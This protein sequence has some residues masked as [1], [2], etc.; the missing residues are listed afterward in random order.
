MEG[1]IQTLYSCNLQQKDEVANLVG[2]GSMQMMVRVQGQLEHAAVGE[3]PVCVPAVLYLHSFIPAPQAAL[4][5]T[6]IPTC[7][8]ICMS[9]LSPCKFML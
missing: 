4:G 3:E 1:Q 8:W 9:S 5:C 2:F 6:P 7:A